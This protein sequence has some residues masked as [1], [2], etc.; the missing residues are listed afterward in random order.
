[1]YSVIPTTSLSALL[2]PVAN[3]LTESGLTNEFSA[4]LCFTVE[5]DRFQQSTLCLTALILL[6]QLLSQDVCLDSSVASGFEAVSGLVRKLFNDYLAFCFFSGVCGLVCLLVDYT[7]SLHGDKALLS[8]GDLI[9]NLREGD[10][11]LSRLISGFD[12]YQEIILTLC[13]LGLSLS[14]SNSET[15]AATRLLQC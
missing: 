9:L 5:L 1:M 7:I 10:L 4:L 14:A 8:T 12:G 15:L 6:L 2:Q 3:L 13:S 11:L